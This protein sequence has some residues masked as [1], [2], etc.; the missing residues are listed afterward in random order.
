MCAKIRR[1]LHFPFVFS[2]ILCT[3]AL[4]FNKHYNLISQN[5]E[6]YL[7]HSPFIQYIDGR[8]CAYLLS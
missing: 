3:F 5:E 7:W 2:N 4:K 8:R 1:N 6:D